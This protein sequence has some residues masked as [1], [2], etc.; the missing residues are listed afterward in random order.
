MALRAVKANVER[1]IASEATNRIAESNKLAEGR[2][3]TAKSR[4]VDIYNQK[5]VVTSFQTTL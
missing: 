2:I 5:L 3:P 1:G 4:A